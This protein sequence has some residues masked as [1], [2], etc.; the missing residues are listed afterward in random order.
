VRLAREFSALALVARNRAKLEKT[1]ALVR[2]AGAEAL[3]IETDLGEVSSAE[4]T[5]CSISPEPFRRS[6]CSR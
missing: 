5:R 4:S 2:S 6:T 3:V 1:A